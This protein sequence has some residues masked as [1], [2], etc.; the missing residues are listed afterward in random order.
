MGGLGHIRDKSK[1][2]DVQ[3]I[4]ILAMR[5]KVPD[6]DFARFAQGDHIN[7]MKSQA[8]GEDKE[9]LEAVPDY[10]FYDFHVKVYQDISFRNKLALTY[11]QGSDVMDFDVD[12]FQFGMDWG[13]K[14]FTA[15]WTHIISD[16]F[17][18]NTYATWSRYAMSMEEDDVFINFTFKNS[19]EDYTG[20]MDLEY[21]PHQDH[22]VRA[23]LQY[24][25]L[26]ADYR[27]KYGDFGITLKSSSSQATAYLQDNWALT[28]LL[29]LQAG[30]RFNYYIPHTFSNSFGDIEYQGE[31]RFDWEPRVSLRYQWTENL[32]TKLAWGRYRQYTTIVSFGSAS[33]S[34]MD[35]WFPC[36]NSYEPSEGYHYI[37]GVESNL[38]W[39]LKGSAEVYYKDM[40][41]LYE[42]NPNT[43][44]VNDGSGLFYAGTG[45]AYGADFY[46]EK[47]TGRLTGWLSYGLGYTWRK[48]ADLNQG[49]PYFPKYDRR[50]SFN[51]IATYQL[52]KSWKL[53]AAWSYGTGQAYTRAT[54]QYELE[55]PDRT[56]PII[57][58]E[59]RNISRLPPYH[60]MD[61]GVRY[62]KK[63]NS[64]ILKQWGF[65]LQIFNLYNRRN[66]WFRY[67]DVEQQPPKDQEIR[68]LPIVP[69]VG[70]EFYF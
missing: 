51:V 23:G 52:T 63:L 3:V 4:I 16:R 13:N 34:F 12:P 58:G 41:H 45:Y 32:A 47:N 44:T 18:V 24:K 57:I 14:T 53:N 36:D 48:F 6:I 28:N 46:I 1:T 37:S 66:V 60:R 26:D 59:Q 38:P 64:K 15:K 20:K 11:F 7:A 5:C 21:Y 9:M 68:M 61:F 31:S 49:R 30:I 33:F 67:V 65:Y 55:M 35:I 27:Q 56:V 70:F 29:R 43:N 62:G 50:H 69:T 8:E 42:F 40:S 25:H 39:G 10:Y 54:S 22:I 17:F 19:I 2:Q